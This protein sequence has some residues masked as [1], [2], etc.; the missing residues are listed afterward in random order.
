MLL[1]GTCGRRE[2]TKGARVV[3]CIGGRYLGTRKRGRG[4]AEVGGRRRGRRQAVVLPRDQG[5]AGQPTRTWKRTRESPARTE[6]R[7]RQR[8]HPVTPTQTPRPAPDVSKNMRPK[9]GGNEGRVIL[10][11][12]APRPTR[13][14]PWGG[15][16]QHYFFKPHRLH[17]LP[18]RSSK[19]QRMRLLSPEAVLW[20]C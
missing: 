17:V 12:A 1:Q 8:E 9:N 13:S 3:P 5:K 15:Q 19:A 18:F 6:R 2:G 7:A 11:R 20:L 14:H 16:N 4:G 10:P